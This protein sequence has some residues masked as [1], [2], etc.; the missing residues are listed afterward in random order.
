VNEILQKTQ[1]GHPQKIVPEKRETRLIRALKEKI[2]PENR[3]NR[4]TRALKKKIVP[5]N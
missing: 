4:L 5:E 3:K 2:V 1:T